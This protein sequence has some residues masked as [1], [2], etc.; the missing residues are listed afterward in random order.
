MTFVVLFNMRDILRQTL[1][2]GVLLSFV[3]LISWP[4]VAGENLLTTSSESQLQLTLAFLLPIAMLLTLNDAINRV[5]TIR[6]FALIAIYISLAV[7]LRPLGLGVA[8]LEPIWVAIIMAG[9]T[10]GVSSGFIVGGLSLL[11]SALVTGGV[12]PWL[13]NQMVLAALIGAGAGILGVIGANRILITLYAGVTTYFFGWFM[14]LWFWPTFSNLQVGIAFDPAA[15]ISER[16][17]SWAKFSL[18]TS[19]GFDVPR[20]IVTATLVWLVAN[21]LKSAVSRLNAPFTTET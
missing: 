10:L 12:G 3:L 7:A 2:S 6:S 15:V 5:I 20:A 17:Q 21:R 14:N 13:G 4:L 19:T 1:L 11:L 16:V 8:G 18:L 9:F